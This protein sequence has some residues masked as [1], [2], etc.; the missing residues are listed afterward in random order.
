MLDYN[1]IYKDIRYI[2]FLHMLLSVVM[3][4]RYL[5]LNLHDLAEARF[6]DDGW[7]QKRRGSCFPFATVTINTVLLYA[8]I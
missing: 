4:W 5:A 8:L 3:R 2:F 1:K 7:M 6:G